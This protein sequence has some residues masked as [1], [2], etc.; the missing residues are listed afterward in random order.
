MKTFRTSD[1]QDYA[2]ISWEAVDKDN[3]EEIE[4]YNQRYDRASKELDE[5]ARAFNT[6]SHALNVMSSHDNFVNALLSCVV[7]D[8]RTLQQSFFSAIFSLIEKYGNLE[9]NY[10]SDLR[11]EASLKACKKIAKFIKDENIY[12]PLI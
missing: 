11:N 7:Q 9:E 6:F 2:R 4:T 5:I 3:P 12:L 10:Y 1:I 8:H